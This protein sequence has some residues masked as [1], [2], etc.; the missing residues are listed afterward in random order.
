[1]AR[2]G[3]SEVVTHGQLFCPHCGFP[4]KIERKPTGNDGSTG[5]MCTN[6]R[7]TWS[8]GGLIFHHPYDSGESNFRRA[9]DID[10]WS[11]SYI[12]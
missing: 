12:K 2:R 9:P 6:S 4:L 11:L 1:M 8:L 10:F 3:P 7:C 5:Y